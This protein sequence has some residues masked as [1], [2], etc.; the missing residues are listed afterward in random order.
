M[1]SPSKFR[2]E[3]D[4]LRYTKKQ[5]HAWIENSPICTKI[6][7]LDFNLQFMSSAGV[8]SLKIKDISQYYGKPYPL[9]FYPAS[10]RDEMSKS[11]SQALKT[12]KVIEQEAAVIDIK[13]N[14]LWFHSTITPISEDNTSI[15][16]FLIVSL[17][18]TAQNH[19]RVAL[20]RLNSELETKVRKRTEELELANKELLQLSE[21]DCLTQLPNRLA[22]E[23]RLKES[24]AMAER[25]D[26]NLS[27]LLIDIDHF[28][29][30]NDHYG[31]D[32]GDIVLQNVAHAIQRSLKRKTDFAARFGGEEFM[33]LLPETDLGSALV[34]A[35]TIRKSI[36]LVQNYNL[37]KECKF[38][39]ASIGISC[40]KGREIITSKLI[41][42]ADTALY[43][44][45]HSGRNNCKAYA[46]PLMLPL[47]TD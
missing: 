14:E 42:Q 45:K 35:E 33:V 9:E 44:A 1:K 22:F 17:E 15:D 16:Y 28:K 12:G 5:G 18:T 7:D 29:E 4:R 20:E 13:G 21:T 10:F 36:S 31:H 8:K 19:A 25:S 40:M 37:L 27:L 30:Y 24:V 47:L 43:S 6:V 32:I 23:R 41:K 34:E 39:T 46:P 11:L 3:Q 26:Q 2:T 38:V